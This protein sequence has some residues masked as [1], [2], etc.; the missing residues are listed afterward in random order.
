M[1]NMSTVEAGSSTSL[2]I[3]YFLHGLA[4]SLLFIVLMLVWVIIA[5]VLIV[6]GLFIGLIIGFIILFY[7]VG[8][9]NA[10]LTR[11]IWSFP[12]KTNFLSLL[13]HGFVLFIVLLLAQIPQLILSLGWPSL[14]M[15]VILFIAYAFVD[16]YIAK[17]VASHWE[18]T[19]EE[20][21]YKIESEMV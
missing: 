16:G 4:F 5:A 1:M 19:S 13:S 11:S 18:F 12:V 21:E 8:G 17:T 7:F 9:L 6:V 10:W 3:R 2:L 15:T 20:H 14:I